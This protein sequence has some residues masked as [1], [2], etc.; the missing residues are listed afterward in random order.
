MAD[1]C[2]SVAEDVTSGETEETVLEYSSCLET[3]TAEELEGE[4][5]VAVLISCLSEA[6]VESV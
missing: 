5:E 4:T 6:E 3:E 2:L 1:S